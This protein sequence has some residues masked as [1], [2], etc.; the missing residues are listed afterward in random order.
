[1]RLRSVLRYPVKGAR[2][3]NLASAQI[4]GEGLVGDRRFM[5]TSPDGRHVSQ[6]ERPALAALDARVSD[7][8]S[9]LLLASGPR[10]LNVSIRRAGDRAKCTLFGE[11]IALWDQGEAA[12]RWLGSI[13]GGGLA[14]SAWLQPLM[15]PAFRL[16]HAPPS[17][18]RG[19][20]ADASPVHLLC[21]ESLRELNARRSAAGLGSVAMDRFRPNFVVAGC[22][23]AHAEDSW[24]SVQ[25]GEALFRVSGP[26]PR[27][28]VPDVRQ[29]SGQ[30]DPP[31]RGPMRSLSGYRARAASGVLFGIYMEPVN[32]G[33]RVHVGDT[34]TPTLATAAT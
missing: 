1:M 34:V 4:G 23:A 25:I 32:P 14:S 33:A 8:G 13:L 26:C 19:G 30:R 15:G 18:R 21:E 6:R 28:T 22:G 27:C 7:D 17:V 29:D 9:T 10:A 2:V 3:E 11:A 5:V 31:S 20:L 24:R 16:R 12:G